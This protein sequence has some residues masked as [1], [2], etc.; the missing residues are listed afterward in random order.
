VA[1]PHAPASAR[2][3]ARPRPGRS[4]LRRRLTA[5]AVAVVIGAPLAA[6]TPAYAK[7]HDPLKHKQRTVHRHVVQAKGD[8]DESSRAL[9]AARGR[10]GAAQT[11]LAGAQKVLAGTRA[12]LKVAAAQDAAA[13]AKLAAAEQAVTLAQAAVAAAKVAVADQRRQIGILAAQNYQYGDPQLMSLAVVLGSGD[14]SEI[15]TQLNTV[16]S[17]MSRQAATLDALR[18]REQDLKDQETKLDQARAAVAEQR[19]IAATNLRRKQQL[20]EQAQA[21]TAEVARLVA[22]RR[23]AAQA[24]ARIR[25][26]DLRQLKALKRQENKIRQQIL[27]RARHQ[28]NHVVADTGGLL[29]RPVPGYVTS[30]YGW[31][32]HPI[33]GYWGLHDGDDFHAPCGTPERAAGSGR[34]VSEYYSSVWGNRLYLDLGKINGHNFTV[35]YNHIERYAARTGEHVSRGETVA[36]AGTTGWSTGC[37]LHFTVMRDGNPVDPQNYM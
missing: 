31:R 9:S 26:H 16:H 17:M 10:L 13:Q 5:A 28:K 2:I 24:A 15:T 21:Q 11:K 23:T 14:P 12:Q 8:L 29:F 4:P 33:Y 37:H 19:Q 3:P 34:V 32:K 1:L 22:T 27:A 36:Y 30:P 35:I 20:E 6:A 18:D 7:H 25:A